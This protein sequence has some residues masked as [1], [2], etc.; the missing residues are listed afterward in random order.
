MHIVQDSDDHPNVLFAAGWIDAS[1]G[2][3]GFGVFASLLS[4]DEVG[5]DRSTKIGATDMYHIKISTAGVVSLLR[6][7]NGVSLGSAT[8]SEMST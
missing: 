2:E 1:A 7:N 4:E 6:G 5:T 8:I 3:A